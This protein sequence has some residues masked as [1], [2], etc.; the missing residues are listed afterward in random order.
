MKYFNEVF[1]GF[2]ISHGLG[3][4]N[5]YII[6][7]GYPKAQC[8]GMN[9]EELIGGICYTLEHQNGGFD[10]VSSRNKCVQYST[11]IDDDKLKFLKGAH[12]TPL[13]SFTTMYETSLN[14]QKHYSDYYG[15]ATIDFD[16][17]LDPFKKPPRCFSNL[18]VFTVKQQDKDYRGVD[19]AQS[20]P[21]YCDMKKSHG[22]KSMAGEN[23]LP[24]N[25]DKIFTYH[26]YCTELRQDSRI[27]SN[28]T[29]SEAEA[30]LDLE[31]QSP[32]Y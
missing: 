11:P 8:E 28:A 15:I 31:E 21:C 29:E 1:R 19:A 7:D 23:W 16:T 25:L 24:D 22:D 20:S 6:R 26:T 14:C 17:P 4:G 27:A 18:S 2:M 5:Y 10:G 32:E 12:D 9:S 13:I 30:G 3:E